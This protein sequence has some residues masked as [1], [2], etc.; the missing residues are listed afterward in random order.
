MNTLPLTVKGIIFDLDGT[1]V[2]SAPDIGN[3][4]NKMLETLGQEPAS[5]EQVQT[6]IGNGLPRLVKRALTKDFNGEPDPERR[7]PQGHRYR[8]TRVRCM[9][10]VT[11]WVAAPPPGRNTR[12][13]STAVASASRSSGRT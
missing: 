9:T 13:A 4:A 1:L 5:R 11:T 12:W 7:G 6:W 8:L 3:A 2:D 10:S